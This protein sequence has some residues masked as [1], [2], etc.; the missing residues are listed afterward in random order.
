MRTTLISG[1]VIFRALG[2]INRLIF[3]NVGVRKH[4]R[5]NLSY[6][7]YTGADVAEALSVSERAG[8][9]KSNLSGMGWRAAGP[10][11]SDVRTRDV[12]GRAKS[13]RFRNS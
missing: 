2:R 11:P 8:S 12:F 13:G 10:S 4:G 1:D 9:V 3:Q 5:R 7:L 6:A